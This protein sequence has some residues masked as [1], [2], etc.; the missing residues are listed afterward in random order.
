M[1]RPL[2]MDV[3]TLVN[4]FVR[5]LISEASWVLT[6]VVA[7][8]PLFEC[9][10]ARQYDEPYLIVLKDTV[11]LGGAK[12]VTIVDDGVLRLHD[13]I[14][15]PNVD[16]LKELTLEDAHSSWYCIHSGATKMYYDLKQHYWWRRMKR[17]IIGHVSRCLNCQQ[18]RYE[19]QRSGGLLQRLEISKWKWERIGID[20]VVGRP[21]T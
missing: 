2:A 14:C 17:D 16:G 10:K 13:Q 21:W 20:F 7:Q 18:V 12:E 6:C 3:Q 19:H 5:Y 9:I 1:E 4:R 11:F 15:V 8:S